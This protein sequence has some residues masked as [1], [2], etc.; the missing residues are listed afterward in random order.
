M[1]DFIERNRDGPEK[2]PSLESGELKDRGETTNADQTCDETTVAA[3]YVHMRAMCMGASESRSEGT[4]SVIAQR[5]R[6]SAMC[7]ST[8]RRGS[9]R[10]H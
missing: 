10:G 1:E 8:S 9:T 4:C 3:V 7:S 6:F 5:G 2:W